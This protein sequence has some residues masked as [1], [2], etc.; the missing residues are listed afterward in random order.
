M[1]PE[2]PTLYSSEVL[3][4]ARSPHGT[5]PL[6]DARQSVEVDNPL[7]GD[8]VHLAIGLNQAGD[9][10]LSQQTRGCALCG[11]SA[12]WM[13]HLMTGAAPGAALAQSQ[14]VTVALADLAPLPLA[15]PAPLKALFAGLHAAPAR[16]GCVRLPWEA[17]QL[18][19]AQACIPEDISTGG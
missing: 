14:S 9:L 3:A 12:S 17:L 11:A 7:C 15:I 6:D 19:L 4:H 10:A 8:R 5:A 16:R 2:R 13:A 1:L 18:A